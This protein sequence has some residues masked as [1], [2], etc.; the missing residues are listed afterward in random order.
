MTPPGEPN[1]FT[2]IYSRHYGDV[3]A[4]CRR[5]VGPD[6]V[7]DLVADVFTSVW[8]RI[9]D[10]PPTESALPWIYR[11]AFNKTGNHWRARSRRKSLQSRLEESGATHVATPIADQVIVREEVREVLDVANRLS[12]SDLE[13]L[14]LSLWEQLTHVEIAEVLAMKPNAVKQRVHRAKKRLIEEYERATGRPA[15][16]LEEPLGD[17]S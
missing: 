4:Y 6:G 5:R 12:V 8:K 14:R 7:D 3:Y 9:E 2:E 1:R 17:E 11:I 10:A 16:P 15:V 13:V